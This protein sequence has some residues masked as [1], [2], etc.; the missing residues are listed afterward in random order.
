MYGG[1]GGIIALGEAPNTLHI[2]ASPYGFCAD[3][4]GGQTLRRV[5]I[6]PSVQRLTRIS[7]KVPRFYLLAVREGFELGLATVVSPN[8]T[9]FR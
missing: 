9:K 6:P 1:E 8:L 4:H 2:S 3:A 5:L 7:S